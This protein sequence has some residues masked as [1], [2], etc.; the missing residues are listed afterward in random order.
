MR[1]CKRT[2]TPESET[3]QPKC[4]F[5]CIPRVSRF[6]LRIPDFSRS[7][8]SPLDT[9]SAYAH[10]QSRP[11]NMLKTPLRSATHATDSTCTGCSANKA[12]RKALG[13][14]AFVN[15]R[16]TKN[17]STELAACKSRFT[18]CGPA[19]SLPKSCA[20][21]MCEIHVIGC[22]VPNAQTIPPSVS[23]FVTW[24]FVT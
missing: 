12:A 3:Y 2:S 24:G 4:A 1:E 10:K 5:P 7:R 20:S 17:K 22:H 9:Y 11:K 15:R 19:G 6:E 8:P 18:K 16:S 13:H 14:R 23:P 21:N